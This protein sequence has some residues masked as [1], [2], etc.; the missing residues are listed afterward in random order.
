MPNQKGLIRNTDWDIL[1]VIDACRYD[2]FARYY[3]GIFDEGKLEKVESPAVWTFG[4]IVETFGDVCWDNVV[5]LKNWVSGYV[6]SKEE[7]DMK[8]KKWIITDL[9]KRWRYQKYAN[10]KFF[11]N[12]IKMQTK[13]EYDALHPSV[14]EKFI[15][16]TIK[17]YP[18]KKLVV[19]YRQIHE[20]YLYW[21]EK[22]KVYEVD[23][24]EWRAGDSKLQR[25][26]R[27]LYINFIQKVLTSEQIWTIINKFG[28][29]SNGPT[30]KIW[31][32]HGWDG[33][34]KGYIEDMILVLKYI[35]KL[36]D[37]YPNKIIAVTSDH[38][39]L[40]GEYGRYGHTTNKRYKEVVEVPWF[41]AG[42]K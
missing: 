12:V 13:K 21:S 41:V 7:F 6:L 14:V 40:L 39:E 4:W 23:E 1:V 22:E 30:G 16:K 19:F 5:C 15:T 31:I 28:L 36:I 24:M 26:K 9:V 3:R 17:E 10:T 42:G 2:Y 8:S 27:L 34:Q 11:G 38:G 35:K 20:P 18:D 29:Q 32:E 33:V 25:F 37:K